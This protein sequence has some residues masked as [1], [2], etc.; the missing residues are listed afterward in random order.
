MEGNTEK[1]VGR[2]KH[3]SWRQMYR[4]PFCGLSRGIQYQGTGDMEGKI[5][6]FQ[7][8]NIHGGKRSASHCGYFAPVKRTSGKH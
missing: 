5:H 6:I 1:Y 8:S 4:T 7:T 3:N 2:G